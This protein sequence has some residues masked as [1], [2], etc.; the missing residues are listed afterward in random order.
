MPRTHLLAV[1]SLAAIASL[2][3]S[4][5][6][7]VLA[8]REDR[9]VL[10]DGRE[11]VGRLE[12]REEQRLLFVDSTGARHELERTKVRAVLR[13]DEEPGLFAPIVLDEATAVAP[14]SY[15]R[16]VA[17]ESGKPG[18]LQTAVA[19]FFHEETRTTLFLVGAVHIGE[20]DYYDRLQDALDSCDVVLFEGVGGGKGGGAAPDADELASMDALTKLQITLNRALG[21]QFQKDGLDYRRPFWKNAD[22]DYPSLS[23]RMKDEGVGLPTDSP[24]FRA[25]M[26]FV[27]GAFDL[28]QAAENPQM[29]RVLRRQAASALAMSDTLFAGQLDKLGAVLIDWRNDAALAVLDQELASGPRGRWLSI[30]YGA[31]HLPDLAAKLEP[32]GFEFQRSDWLDAWRVE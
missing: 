13:A 3:W 29:Q 20:P 30:F 9:I 17:P 10:K 23:T 2:A 31:A 19:R 15:V 21:L 28:S 18:H 4:A 11:L 32:R 24:L 1:V 8:D 12:G 27:I 16:Y 22:V 14:T 5:R 7:P 26:R 25:L 6:A